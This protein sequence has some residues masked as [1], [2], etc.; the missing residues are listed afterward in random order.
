MR[1][2]SAF[3]AGSGTSVRR[4]KFVIIGVPKESYPG[5]RRVALVPLVIPNLMKVG[6]SVVVEAGAGIAAGYPDAPYVEKGARIASSRA[7]VFAQADLIV[8]VLCYG[9]NDLTGEADLPLLK[10]GQVLIGF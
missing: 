6:H 10:R 4:G 7:E 9:S 5:E 3:A 2:A 1:G 8:Q